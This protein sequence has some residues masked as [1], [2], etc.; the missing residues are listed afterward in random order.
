MTENTQSPTIAAIRAA[1]DVVDAAWS[2]H[3]HA[4][5]KRRRDLAHKCGVIAVQL[6]ATR[7]RLVQDGP[8]YID[9]GWSMIDAGRVALANVKRVLA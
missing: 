8:A 4:V 3:A 7:T 5:H 1:S 6:D 2:A 9:A